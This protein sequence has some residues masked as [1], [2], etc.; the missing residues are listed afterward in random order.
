MK[1]LI[2]FLLMTGLA[3]ANPFL[4]CDPP[5]PDQQVENYEIF[6][7]GVLVASPPAQPDGSLKYDIVGI[8][9]GQYTFTAK[10]VNAW[11]VSGLSN[12]YV[13]PAPAGNPL[14]VGLS[15]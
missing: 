6:Q 14:G 8:T 4:V 13:S 11:G 10:A 5:P 3:S 12:P 15:K 2:I 9:P 7:D 1:T